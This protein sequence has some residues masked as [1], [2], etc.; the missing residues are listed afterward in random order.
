[1]NIGWAHCV[2]SGVRRTP[3]D[4]HLSRRRNPRSTRF[5]LARSL[6]A[7]LVAALSVGI[8]GL[9]LVRNG[10]SNS[11]TTRDRAS[12][13][14]GWIRRPPPPLTW[15]TLRLPATTEVLAFPADMAAVRSDP[16]TV[17]VERRRSGRLLAY[18][19]ATAVE[20]G[21]A[22]PG[23][24]AFR[25]THLRDEGA[26]DVRLEAADACLTVGERVASCVVDT[27][28]NGPAIERYREVA[29]LVSD[30]GAPQGVVIGAAPLASWH[31][32]SPDVERSVLA[33]LRS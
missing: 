5:R 29:C 24:A 19:N 17:S 3:A 30:R 10:S 2:V 20:G 14:F 8:I 16:G 13:G 18:L 21:E 7:L 23:F 15:R 9:A 28:A 25:L 1:V 26:R 33:F 11:T 6:A 27:Y 22:G 12:M 31:R 4:P 32:Q